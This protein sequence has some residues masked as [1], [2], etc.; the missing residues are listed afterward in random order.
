MAVDA[1]EPLVRRV[2]NHLRSSQQDLLDLSSRSEPERLLL[3]RDIVTRN[4]SFAEKANAQG[5]DQLARLLR[6]FEPVLL[7]M[8]AGDAS[9]EDAAL[10]RSQLLFELNVVLTKYGDD[11]SKEAGTT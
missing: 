3:I 1:G 11:A 6:A 10:L 7:D 4:R 5:D 9:T 2:T 8:A